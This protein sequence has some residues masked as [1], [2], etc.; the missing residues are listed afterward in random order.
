MGRFLT[1]CSLTILAGAALLFTG[2]SQSIKSADQPTAAKAPPAVAELV[3]AKT[4]FGPMYKSAFGWS[5]DVKLLHMTPKEV[6]GF[7]NEAGKSAVWEATFASASKHQLRVYTYAIE[8]VPAP[9]HKGLS[10]GIPMAWAGQ[11][12]DSMPIEITAFSVDSDAAYHA[13]TTDAAA[14]LAKNPGKPLSSLEL[15]STYVHQS[16]VWY[17]A[18]GDKK[19]GYV[20]LVDATS[21][22]VY[23][24]K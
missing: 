10:V 4:A 21:G 14:W 5:S 15:G 12:R 2:C 11:T 16:P 9:A 3:T 8:T 24:R 18:W 6:P 19:A 17:V 22:Q 1:R 20:A 23:K 13:S 7:K